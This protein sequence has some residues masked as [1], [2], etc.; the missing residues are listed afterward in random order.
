MFYFTE[1]KDISNCLAGHIQCTG[2][3]DSLHQCTKCDL[4]YRAGGLGKG[5]I[6]EFM[7]NINS[8]LIETGVLK[9]IESLLFTCCVYMY[10]FSNRFAFLI[11]VLFHVVSYYNF[12][13]SC[14]GSLKPLL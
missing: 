13:E 4:G 14:T 10:S 12:I 2:S 7:D 3:S 6:G 5:C 8:T 9:S 1:C 11:V